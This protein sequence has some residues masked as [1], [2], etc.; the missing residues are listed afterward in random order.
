MLRHWCG[1]LALTIGLAAFS[2]CDDAVDDVGLAAACLER[3]DDN[4]AISHMARHLKAH[5]EK[6]FVRFTFAELLFRHDRIDEA[7]LEYER[8]LREAPAGADKNRLV[9]AHAQLVAISERNGD[10]YAEHLHRGIGLYLLTSDSDEAS[11][12]Q[13]LLFKS[14]KELR[15][16]ARLRSQDARPHW[17]LFLVWSRLSQ[18]LE[19]NRHLHRS[20]ELAGNS[21]L[22]RSERADLA[23]AADNLALDR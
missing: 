12:R 10:N 20:I 22:T 17:H 18:S 4:A 3:G 5:P 23:I 13:E 21:D 15:F 8:F 19:A 2:A 6:S 1:A 7:K 11:A 16:A 14:A 9:H